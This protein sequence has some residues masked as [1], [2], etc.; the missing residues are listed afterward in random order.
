MVTKKRESKLRPLV[1]DMNVKIES[2]RVFGKRNMTVYSMEVNLARSIPEI[3]DGLKPV[4]RRVLYAANQFYG[5]KPVKTAKIVGLTLG[6]YHPHGDQSIVGAIETMV[7]HP[8]PTLEGHGEWGSLIDSAAAMRYTLTR[9]SDYGRTM[10]HPDYINKEVTAFV[11]NYDDSDIEPVTLPAQLPYVLMTGAEGVGVGITTMLPSFTAESLVEV[12]SRMLSGET[13]QAVDFAKTLKYDHKWGGTVV[14]TK[15]NKLEWLKLFTSTQARVLFEAHLEVLREDKTV[16]INDWPPGLNP[17]KFVE[18][19]RTFKECLSVS[20]VKGMQYE[21]RMRKDHN[22]VQFDK[23]VERVRRAA[24]VAR[25][26]KLNVTHSTA[27]VVDGVT[28][29]DT[30]FLALSVPHMIVMWLKGRLAL[31][32]RSLEY[33][34]KKQQAAIDFSELL[35]YASTKLDVVFKALKSNNPDAYMVTHMKITAAQ[36][37]QILD[38]QVRR[39]SKLDQDALKLKLKEQRKHMTQLEAWTKRPKA[40]IKADM[41]GIM[42]AIKDDR[43][44]AYKIANQVLTIA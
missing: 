24:T 32:L 37:K 29:M 34:T 13:L 15:A 31:E 2:L 36:A 39:L 6:N 19:V 16:L 14:N 42:Q 27:K 7:H 12:M 26:F 43:A 41:E 18:N 20:N 1:A 38:L 25:S 28:M 5:P 40:K 35:I 9:L 22:F 33:R 44:R 11:P 8:T 3:G 4:Q 21:I 10:F 17:E 23:F 30:D